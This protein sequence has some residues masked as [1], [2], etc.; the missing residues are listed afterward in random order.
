[1]QPLQPVA[2]EAP[3]EGSDPRTQAVPAPRSAGQRCTAGPADLRQ[4]RGACAVC[5]QQA[6]LCPPC[7]AVF[8]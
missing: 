1:M 7:S 6:P 4:A 3:G 5:R 8:R 2:P